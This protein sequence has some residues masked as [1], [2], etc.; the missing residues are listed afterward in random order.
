MLSANVDKN[1]PIS[2]DEDA[3]SP[4][5]FDALSGAETTRNYS[6]N[7][8]LSRKPYYIEVILRRVGIALLM[9]YVAFIGY[10]KARYLSFTQQAKLYIQK[11]RR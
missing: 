9:K 2:L 5:D 1:Y 3:F 10:V 8:S 4:D 6:Q 11:Y 7:T